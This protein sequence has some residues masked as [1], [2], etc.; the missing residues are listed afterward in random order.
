MEWFRRLL[1]VSIQENNFYS[2]I[3]LARFGTPAFQPSKL[4]WPNVAGPAEA[5]RRAFLAG[6]QLLMTSLMFDVTS[7]INNFDNVE[8]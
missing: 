6:G 5:S 8:N 2:F 1:S 4:L 3:P 7:I